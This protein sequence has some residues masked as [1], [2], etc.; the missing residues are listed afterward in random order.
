MYFEE[1]F[2]GSLKNGIKIGLTIDEAR[3]IDPTLVY[4]D[5]EEDFISKQNYWLEESLETKKICSISI[6][7]K[8][9]ENDNLFF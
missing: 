5:W 4:D 1:G 3:K 9:A 2:T 8:E 6:Y 7:I